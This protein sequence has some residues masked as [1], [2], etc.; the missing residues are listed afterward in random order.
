MPPQSH[1]F[2]LIAEAKICNAVVYTSL[3]IGYVEKP[4]A[5]EIANLLDV[6]R[7]IMDLYYPC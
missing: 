1:F 2:Q 6:E 5:D 4:V 3:R 7:A